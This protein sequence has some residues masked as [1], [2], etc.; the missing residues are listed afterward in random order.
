MKLQA[1]NLQ[2]AGSNPA[3][4]SNYD[5]VAQ[6]I[7]QDVSPHLVVTD[8]WNDMANAKETTSAAAGSNPAGEVTFPF[9]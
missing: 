1:V 5:P 8:E 4:V 2:V 3:R 6:R 7:E 9:W